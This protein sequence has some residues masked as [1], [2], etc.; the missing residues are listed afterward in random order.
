MPNGNIRQLFRDRATRPSGMERSTG[1]P[2]RADAR[3]GFLA[4]IGQAAKLLT[5]ALGEL[6]RGRRI[7]LVVQTEVADCA[8]AAL[9]MAGAVH[10]G[11]LSLAD[12]KR[13]VPGGRDG[14]TA[15]A[16]LD[17]ARRAGLRGR[18]VRS[19]LE[20]LHH[21]PR[22]AILHWNFNHYVV[23]DHVY[24]GGVAVLDPGLGRR[25]V[26]WSEVDKSFTGVALV[27]EP[28]DESLG[29]A[30][31]PGK[32]RWSYVRSILRHRSAWAAVL[33][34]SL[35]LQGIALLVP[36]VS[37]FIIDR[38]IPFEDTRLLRNV[39]LAG[40]VVAI[41][42]FV[43]SAGRAL[44][45]A[46]LR[47]VI[48][49]RLSADVLDHM[50][51]LPYPYFQ[52]RSTGDLLLR[53]R[54]GAAIRQIVTTGL[55]STLLDG[56]VL[57]LSFFLLTQVDLSLA[58][59]VAGA[60]LLDILVVAA[61]WPTLRDLAR[62][63][64]ET[65][66]RTQS[67]L[68]QAL[69]GIETIKAGGWENQVFERWSNVFVDELNL[70]L[71]R[72][73]I[74]AVLESLLGTIRFG[75]PFAVLTLGMFRVLD[76]SLSVGTAVAAGMLATNTLVPLAS[77]LGS[78]VSLSALAGYSA[79]LADLLEEEPERAGQGTALLP[80]FRGG[81]ELR[82]AG[83][84]YPGSD[85]AFALDAVSLEIP[86]GA[87]VA[88]VGPSGAG[89]STLAM[90]VAGL[91]R[92]TS[93]EIRYDGVVRSEL[94]LG[95]LRRRVGVVTQRPYLFAGTIR[96]NL[97]LWGDD[98]GDD[99]LAEATRL[100]RIDT[101]I[102]ALPLGLDTQLSDAASNF[103]GGQRQRLALARALVHRPALLVLDEA[104]SAVDADAEM[105]LLDD[106]RR[107]PFSLVVVT[108]RAATVRDADLVLTVDA[109]RVVGGNRPAARRSR[110][111]SRPAS[112][113]ARNLFPLGQPD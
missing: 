97:A 83:F 39:V 73:R 27:F 40:T 19:E 102:A 77:L 92:P 81:V 37:G 3:R 76:N 54:S 43:L 46:S 51:G 80:H 32:P 14:T 69:S 48:D 86:P 105:A 108:H 74:G 15:R 47:T 42:L 89:K 34:V 61:A 5:V 53:V 17:G 29:A 1:E 85:K 75:A 4:G 109:G 52:T 56:W 41:G 55:L 63:G 44:A 20:G 8:A 59:V 16:L 62:T 66:A 94:D 31:T 6:R 70:D 72:A 11:R 45:L 68:V 107:Q 50:L 79:R 22:G 12:A 84:R 25:R 90:L 58:L 110:T 99:D 35:A 101:D 26:P 38:V 30:G 60:G 104:T 113:S 88:L 65:Q 95:A 13:F 67:N 23:L 93:G 87:F 103:S 18:A 82:E 21:L 111:A 10:G 2:L 9:A 24:R 98:V 100:A 112:A 49:A 71:D 91:L 96:D 28:V 36:F 7:P 33:G 78:G 57:V 64:L 106:L